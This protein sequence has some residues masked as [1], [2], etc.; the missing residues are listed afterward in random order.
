MQT[1]FITTYFSRAVYTEDEDS[2]SEFIIPVGSHTGS[3]GLNVDSNGNFDTVPR[4]GCG[5]STS[6]S[7]PVS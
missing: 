1:L 7:V 5:A 6:T 2:E 4:P 3:T